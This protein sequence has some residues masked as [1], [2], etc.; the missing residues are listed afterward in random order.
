M[1][2]SA[3]GRS[4]CR[5]GAQGQER[6]KAQADGAPDRIGGR[7]IPPQIGEPAVTFW[8]NYF[9]RFF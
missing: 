6:E 2:E 9:T 7:H 3:G 4:P 8:G 1:R 5:R